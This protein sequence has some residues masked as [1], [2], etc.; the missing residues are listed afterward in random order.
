MATVKNNLCVL[1]WA[2][3]V[4]S[5]AWPNLAQDQNIPFSIAKLE[6]RL[7]HRPFE[8]IGFTGIRHDNDFTKRATLL[9]EDSAKI[10]VKWKRAARGGDA[11]NNSPRYELAAYAFQKLFLDP[12]NFVV[13]PTVGRS[14]SVEK[15]R[16]LESGVKPTFKDI[17]AVFFVMQYWLQDVTTIG[18]YDKKRL[19]TNPSYA[20]HLSNLN[21]FTY[22]IKHMDSN[23]GNFLISI[24][25]ANMRVFAVDN[26][27]AFG[28]QKS[29]RGTD[30][31]ELRVKS[32][33]KGTLSRLRKL[34]AKDIESTLEVVAQYEIQDGRLY[35]VAP[36]ENLNKNRGVRR[37]GK[38]I[39]FGLTEREIQGVVRRLEKLLKRVDSGKIQTFE[40]S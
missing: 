39:Q 19:K 35:P 29:T 38:L 34:T 7:L 13:P 33:P 21:I 40:S 30:W 24:Y 32:L 1:W 15:Y 11:P 18:V 6:F 22:L 12:E 2:I 26:S 3:F 4:V 14:M 37:S 17:D 25:G 10:R 16:E 31:K 9:F 28:T 5:S 20:K 8:V 27:L 23:V 36:S